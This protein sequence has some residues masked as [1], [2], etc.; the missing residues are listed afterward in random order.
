[1]T[2]D[3]GYEVKELLING[4]SVGAVSSY[5]I[6]SVSEDIQVTAVFG[7]TEE[8]KMTVLPKACR[9]PPSKCTT[10]KVKSAK[11][12]LNFVTRSLTVTKWT[13]MKFSVPQRKRPTL[14]RRRG[15][16]QKPTKQA[17]TTKM[18]NP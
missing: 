14:E 7:E 18:E 11:A 10:R 16:S 17:D 8:A 3:E 15:L 9:I 2:A 5:T 6:K 1:M 4:K 13:I 12:G